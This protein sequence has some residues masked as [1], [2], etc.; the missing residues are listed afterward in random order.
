MLESLV[1]AIVVFIVVVAVAVMVMVVRCWKRVEQGTALIITGAKNPTVHFSKAI[2]LP[3]VRQ[4]EI[5]DISVRRIEI[6][7]H[8]SEG[9]VCKDNVRADIKVAF[10]VRVNNNEEDVLKV[11]QSIGAARASETQKLIELFDA[12]FSE[13]LKTVGKKFDFVAL[14]TSREEF[15]EE[16]LQI[17]GRDL[18]GYVLDDAA[19][20]YLE[21]T[22]LD[23]LD[24]KNILDSEGIKK[25]T[26]LTARQQ[27]LANSITREKEK[28]LKKQDVEA[29]EAILELEKQLAEAEAKQLRE[30]ETVQAREQAEAAKVQ[31][32]ERLKSERARITTEE[33]VAIATENKDRQVIVAMR[34]K[35]RTDQVEKERVEKDRMLEV[36][37]R[38]RVV[39]L[40]DIEKE[41][42]IEVQKKEIQDV[43][44]ERVIVERAVVEEQERIKDTQEFATADRAKQVA[45]TDAEKDAQE[46]LVKEI[47][48]AEAKRD[49]ARFTA[50]ET[51]ITAEAVRDASEREAVGKKMLAEGVTAEQA[52]TGLAEATV[53]ESKAVA[54]AKGLEARAV[55]IEKEGTAEANVMQLKF[56]ADAQGITDKAEAMKLFN[57]AGKEHEE[58][59]IN[60]EKEKAIELAAIDAQREIAEQQAVIISQALKTAKIDIVGG[61]SE[62]FDKITHAITSGKAVDRWVD[63]SR[64]LTDVK[65]TFFNSDPAY[66]K[67]RMEYFTEQFGIGSED[68]KNLS[69]AALLNKMKNMTDDTGSGSDMQLLAGLAQQLG[70]NDKTLGQIC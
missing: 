18:N 30:I 36:T 69:V 51:V 12:K 37:E 42:V 59:K 55:A 25:I 5:M 57:D 45:I 13:A 47:K 65:N 64:T 68:V 34:N 43:I 2:L 52:A 4:A 63:N 60:L 46:A 28:T 70:F 3:L 56:G 23:K 32:E 58:F 61:E 8:G 21:Q 35:E 54:E 20:D 14:Y 26:D 48:A 27:V 19:I 16:I 41:K 29:R 66:F 7:R 53:I 50:E 49:A 24:P 38:E 44:R 9:L 40:A 67:S 1:G 62:F 11:A 15:K 17:I 39:S 6:F 22:P 33:E 31:E 10:F